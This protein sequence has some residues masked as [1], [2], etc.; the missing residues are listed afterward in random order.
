MKINLRVRGISCA[1]CVKEIESALK[2]LEGVKKVSANLSS[3]SVFVEF[4]ESKVSLAKIIATI[5]ENG[6]TV[7]RERRELRI[8]IEGMSCVMCVKAIEKSLNSLPGVLEKEVLIGRAR[9]VYDSLST[10]REE[11]L[12]SIEKIGY[13]VIF[14]GEDEFEIDKEIREKNLSETK[15]KVAISLLCGTILMILTLTEIHNFNLLKFTIA[16]IAIAYAGRGIFSKTMNALKSKVITM[17]VMYTIGI[18]SAYFGSLFASLKILRAEF[19][20]YETSVF[21]MAFLLLGKYL[22]ER[23]RAKT[24]EAL[25]KLIALQPKKVTVVKEGKEVE[26]S[27]HELQAGDEVIV[28]PGEV[29]PVDGTVFDGESFVDESTMT[30]E[31]IPKLKKKGDSVFGGT[32]NI[33]SVLK[34]RAEKVG[35]NTL[36]SQI[37]RIVEEAQ[38][39]KATI[40]RTADKIVSNFIPVVVLVA[41]SSFIYWYIVENPLVAFTALLSVLVI[42]CPCAFGLAIPTALAVGIGKAAEYGILIKNGSSLEKIKHATFILLDKTGTITEGVPRLEKIFCLDIDEKEF[43]LLLASAEKNS[44]HPIARAIIERALEMNLKIEDPEIFEEISGKGVKAVVKGRKVLA[45]NENF[46]I[47]QGVEFLPEVKK[48]AEEMTKNGNSVVFVA[49]DNR[50]LGAIGIADRIKSGAFD[51]VRE[52][53]KRMKVGIVTGDSKIV[54]NAIAKQLGIDFVEAEVLPTKKAEI[55]LKL[56]NKGEVVVFV[57]DG[58]NDAPALARADVGIAVGNARDIAMEAGDIVL[59][60]NELKLLTALLKLADKTISKIKQNIFWAMFYNLLL[61]PFAGGL[62]YVFFGFF[63]RPEWAAGAM[64]MSS[65]SVVTNSLFLRRVKL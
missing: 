42:A 23:T 52:L 56:Q 53:K 63:I 13:K 15:R 10:T 30:G 11:I 39:S 26:I 4:E 59:L 62:S 55:V 19:E 46:L 17:E 5:E 21:L 6:Y 1:T 34:V 35:K 3:S 54:A 32:I 57:G 41:I 40:Q 20:F 22:E 37:I 12:N 33:N 9:I 14:E 50:V 65:V 38:F 44:K 36:I 8:K 31:A 49:I 58:I 47:E 2:K 51:M 28:K 43:L 18:L 61:I 60:R 27:F 24:S 25:K 48:V 16:T 45:G 7:V 29:I 64:S